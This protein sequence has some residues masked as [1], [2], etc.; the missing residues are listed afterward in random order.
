MP[1][2]VS[3]TEISIVSD[4]ERNC[5]VT[6]ISRNGSPSRASAALS[7]RLTMT[8]RRSWPSARIAGRFGSRLSLRWM[9]SRRPEKSCSASPTA[10]VGAVGEEVGGG[11]RKELGNRVKGKREG[12]SSPRQGAVQSRGG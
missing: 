1:L 11:E 3:E 10:A 6:T 7:I 2:P 12:E 8:L 5:V 9:P 4:S